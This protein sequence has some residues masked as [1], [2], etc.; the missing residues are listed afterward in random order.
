MFN[1]FLFTVVGSL[2]SGFIIAQIPFP[3]GQKFKAITQQGLNLSA[4]DPSYVSSMSWC[5][6][7]IYGLQGVL[8]L[9]VGDTEGLDDMTAMMNPQMQMMQ[10]AAGGMEQKNYQALF[11]GE[12]ENYELID[13]KFRLEDAEDAF[14]AKFK[15][16]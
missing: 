10:G 9:I 1:M 4:L 8:S 7:L 2:F 14:L 12:K 3:L 15:K 6:L 5:F 16:V 13:Y 11:K